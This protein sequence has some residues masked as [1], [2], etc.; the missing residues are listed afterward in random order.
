[1]RLSERHLAGRHGLAPGRPR[2]A[3]RAPVR[4]L[5]CRMAAGSVMAALVVGLTAVPALASTWTVH[6]GGNFSGTASLGSTVITDTVTGTS[7]TCKSKITGT[8]NSG[9]GLAGHHIGT[10]TAAAFTGC[11]SSVLGANTVTAAGFPWFLNAVSYASP[12]T[13]GRVTGIHLNLVAGGCSAVVTGTAVTANDG[14]IN[15][16]Y[17][18][19]DSAL[20]FIAPAVSL[21]F[22]GVSVGCSTHLFDGDVATYVAT[23]HPI[24]P[25]QKITSP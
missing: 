11:T 20:K 9:T 21:A 10:I 3:R 4:R 6:P 22:Y 7:V 15:F 5:S 8:L 13:S 1:M 18:N 12:I 14:K 17:S 16:R 2:K 19:A 25:S 23:Y 24:T